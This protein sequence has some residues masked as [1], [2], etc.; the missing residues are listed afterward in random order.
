MGQAGATRHGDVLIRDPVLG[1]WRP[2]A[3]GLAALAVATVLGWWRPAA[4]GLAALAV[5]TVL[6]WWRPAAPGLAAL[7]V[8]TVGTVG[9]Y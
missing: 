7:A 9:L 6:G 1:W 8:A 2:A 3:P 5:A 4:P